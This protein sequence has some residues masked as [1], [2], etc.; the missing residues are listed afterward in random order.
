MG[1]IELT[2][3]EKCI[4]LVSEI[5]SQ[6]NTPERYDVRLSLFY[7]E[8]IVL[9]RNS[10]CSL[11]SSWNRYDCLVREEWDRRDRGCCGSQPG[12]HFTPR[13]GGGR[14]M[15]RMMWEGG[16]G[17]RGEGAFSVKEQ[18]APMVPVSNL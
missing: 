3:T 6:L 5:L 1:G 17:R 11:T 13:G 16:L 12:R 15:N 7:P 8:E 10:C 18:F 14:G 2:D 4:D 9:Q